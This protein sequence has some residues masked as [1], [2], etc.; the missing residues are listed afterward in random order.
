MFIVIE[1]GNA[2]GKSTTVGK[3][4]DVMNRNKF[5]G[6]ETVFLKTPTEP[7]DSMWQQIERDDIDV[8]TK[9]YFFRAIIQ[10][11]SNKTMKLLNDGYNVVLEAYLYETEAFDIALAAL[12]GVDKSR[13]L[14]HFNYTDLLKPDIVFF[15]DIPYEERQRRIKIRAQNKKIPFWEEDDFQKVYNEAYREIAKREGFYTI[16]TSK[17]TADVTV[18][19]ILDEIE[20]IKPMGNRCFFD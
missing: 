8:L 15:L 7:F 17:N 20:K 16:D 4:L 19:V 5:R 1:G 18:N 12:G 2:S 3:L 13:I 10:N 14:R 6:K 9:Y 11:E